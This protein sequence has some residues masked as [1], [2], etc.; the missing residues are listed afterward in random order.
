MSEQR[1]RGGGR[2]PGIA[3][4]GTAQDL[5]QAKIW[6]DALHE[7]GI[8][9]LV[10]NRRPGADYSYDASFDL[11]GFDIFVPATALRNARGVLGSWLEEAR[12][13]SGEHRTG[14]FVVNGLVV[15]AILLG[16]LFFAALVIFLN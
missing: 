4:L 16:G 3:L 7:A 14:D 9:C 11:Q 12:A 2:K 13:S 5:A 15:L 6:E 1:P 8:P 10:R